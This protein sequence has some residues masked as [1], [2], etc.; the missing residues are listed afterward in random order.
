MWE[1]YDK[2][3]D[4]IKDKLG[5]KFPSKDVYEYKYLKAKVR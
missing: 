2:T 4:A 1:K 5:I 3:F